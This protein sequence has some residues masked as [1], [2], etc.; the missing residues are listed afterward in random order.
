LV[1]S[2]WVVV[3]VVVEDSQVAEEQEDFNQMLR[4]H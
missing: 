2:Q 3:V 1:T 4:F